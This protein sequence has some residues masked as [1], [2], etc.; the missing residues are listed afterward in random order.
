[1]LQ[2]PQLH[3]QQLLQHETLARLLRL[4][5]RPRQVHRGDRVG[6]A[7]QALASEQPGGQRVRQPAHHRQELMDES[8]QKLG[9]DLLARRVDRDDT[10][11]VDP[12]P[13]LLEDLVPLDD[14]LLAPALRAERPAQAELHALA[15]HL[16]QVLLVEPDGFHRSGIVAQQH[17]DDV[18]PPARRALRPH[19]HDLATDGRLLPYPEVAD[20]LAIAEVLVAAREVLDEVGHRV[21]GRTP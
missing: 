16:G 9:R 11:G 10:L 7:G 8:S 4:R 15:Q 3:E 20:G 21:P 6:P 18:H 17:L 2:Q 13:V 1:M 14:E 19:A 5:E 12:L